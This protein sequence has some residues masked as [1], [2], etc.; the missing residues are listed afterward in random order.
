VDPKA[1]LM[2]YMGTY[3][4]MMNN[5]MLTIDPDGQ[6]PFLVVAAAIVKIAAT[7][8]AINGE[9]Y[10]A[11]IAFSDGGFNNWSWGQ[12]GKSAAMGA[13]S[14]VATAGIGKAFGEVGKIGLSASKAAET[15]QKAFNIGNELAR[16]GAHGLSNLMLYSV[17]RP[18]SVRLLLVLFHLLED[19]LCTM[20][21][22]DYSLQVRHC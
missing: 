5:P 9:F 2:P 20:P 3:A 4:G 13:V 8:A 15:G 19:R 14:G 22:R 16:A 18:I 7:G 6:L 12:F 1:G 17:I 21:V 11:S 10:T